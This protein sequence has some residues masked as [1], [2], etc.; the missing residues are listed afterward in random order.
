MTYTSARFAQGHG[1]CDDTLIRVLVSR[2]EVDLKKIMEEYRAMY[3]VSLQDDILVTWH[4]YDINF[5]SPYVLFLS[6]HHVNIVSEFFSWTYLSV[7]HRMTRGDIIRPSCL[8][9]VDLTE[10]QPLHWNW[11]ARPLD[12]TEILFFPN[13]LQSIT[14]SWS[15]PINN[16]NHGIP[17][18]RGGD[19][20]ETMQ[21]KNVYSFSMLFDV[22]FS[23]CRPAG[24][25][26]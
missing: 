19:T 22:F 18:T 23:L 5:P 10:I 8:D 14:L 13:W 16:I 4:V 2:S 1:T 3:D 15:Y 12:S 20:V 21:N 17:L 7:I 24:K 26:I 11:L 9:C 6:Q 25:W